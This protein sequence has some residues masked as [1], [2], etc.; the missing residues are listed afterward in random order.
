[1]NGKEPEVNTQRAR[2]AK[3]RGGRAPSG[4]DRYLP[5]NYHIAGEDERYVY[6]EGA[7]SHGWT[8]L[9]YV[10]PR[11]ASGLIWAEEVVS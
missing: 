1:V 11:L 9:G 5:A 8:L 7:D 10:I 3:D 6:I 4:L 2:V